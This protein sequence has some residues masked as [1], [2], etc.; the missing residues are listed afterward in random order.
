MASIGYGIWL[1]L[2]LGGVEP[3]GL[4]N[5]PDRISRLYAIHTVR[6]RQKETDRDRPIDRHTETDK[7][8]DR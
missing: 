3:V 1:H 8:R 7:D 6:H 4:Y 2:S 5:P